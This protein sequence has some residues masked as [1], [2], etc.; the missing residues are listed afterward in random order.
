[1]LLVLLLPLLSLASGQTQDYL[2]AL[3]D[4]ILD[5]QV[6]EEP[7]KDIEDKNSEKQ[8]EDDDDV[9]SNR[10]T[11]GK[12]GIFLSQPGRQLFLSGGGN[13]GGAGGGKVFLSSGGGP[14]PGQQV[15]LSRGDGSPAQVFIAQGGAGGGPGD[16][17]KGGRKLKHIGIQ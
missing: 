1:M 2:D 5:P 7:D 8:D 11:G 14:G 13:P 6:S 4:S 17:G 3:V 16:G 15:F 9:M 12:G 10:Q